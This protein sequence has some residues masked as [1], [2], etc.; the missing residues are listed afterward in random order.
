M[1]LQ[2]SGISWHFTH[3][4]P[5]KKNTTNHERYLVFASTLAPQKICFT[6]NCWQLETQ[7][8]IFHEMMIFPT[9]LLWFSG[10]DKPP[11]KRTQPL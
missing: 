2:N 4:F 1:K 8:L 6:G 3:L 7:K 10:K 11:F 5:L 9:R